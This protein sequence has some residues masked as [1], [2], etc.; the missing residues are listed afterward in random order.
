MIDLNIP[1]CWGKADQI[2]TYALRVAFSAFLCI[3]CIDSC[4]AQAEPPLTVPLAAGL[5]SPTSGCDPGRIAGGLYRNVGTAVSAAGYFNPSV[6][7]AATANANFN[8]TLAGNVNAGGNVP[9]YSTDLNGNVP[10]YSTPDL[11]GNFPLYSTPTAGVNAPLYSNFGLGNY[12]GTGTS[13]QYRCQCRSVELSQCHSS[14]AVGA[15]PLAS[16]LFALFR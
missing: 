9:L 10:L 12:S 13:S 14:W 6:N 15:L 4:F 1:C 3:G 8:S 7:P 16:P 11:G 2:A 5:P